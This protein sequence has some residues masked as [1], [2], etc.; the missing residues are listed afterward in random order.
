MSSNDERASNVSWNVSWNSS[1]IRIEKK[2]FNQYYLTNISC[3]TI[4]FPFNVAKIG[5]WF[6]L[7]RKWDA[8]LSRSNSSVSR[9]SHFLK[10]DT[11]CKLDLRFTKYFQLNI[12]YKY[13]DQNKCTSGEY[14]KIKKSVSCVSIPKALNSSANLAQTLSASTSFFD[15]MML[16]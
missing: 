9:V 13:L 3:V 11:V 10:E 5:S 2:C 16:S 8:N 4:S 12:T 15:V 7:R 6:N 1:W 14:W